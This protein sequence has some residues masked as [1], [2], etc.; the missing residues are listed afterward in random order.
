[1]A[2]I[3][4]GKILVT[5]DKVQEGIKNVAARLYEEN[6]DKDSL[7]VGMLT[8]SFIFTTLVM[9]EMVKIDPLLNPE[10]DFM[11][12]GSYGS[13]T[14]ASEPRV[15][16]DLSESTQTQGRDV[17]LMDDIFETGETLKLGVRHLKSLGAAS[18][19]MTLL[20]ARESTK[21]PDVLTEFEG[22]KEVIT[23]IAVIIPDDAF[24]IGVGLNG[25]KGGR[26]LPYI[27]AHD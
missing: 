4:H 11:R 17:E 18:V 9:M 19:G 14:I 13:T 8:G 10:V 20:S 2:R 15:L 21:P 23:R 6:K 27:A 7:Y 1:M 24:V 5:A 25:P 26:V 12:I 16:A 22:F 3:E